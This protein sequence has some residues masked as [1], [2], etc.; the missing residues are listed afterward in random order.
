ML[1]LDYEANGPKIFMPTTAT[2]ANSF[3]A[4]LHLALQASSSSRNCPSLSDHDWLSI[5][6]LR[7]LQDHPSGRSFLL[8]LAASNSFKPVAS[9]LFFAGLASSRR[10]LLCAEVNTHLCSIL[11][12]QLPD[13][14]ADCPSL[15]GFDIYAGDGHYHAAACHD[16]PDSE[17]QT[18]RAVGH[19][20]TLNLRSH[21]LSYLTAADAASRKREHDMRALKRMDKETLRHG[22][23][24]GRKVIYIWDKA[25]ID[26]RAW[27]NWKQSAAIYFISRE[28]DNMKLT[29]NAVRPWDTSSSMN[30]GV[31]ADE[32]AGSSNGI[33]LR[34]VTYQDAMQGRTYTFITNEMTLEPGVIAHLYKMRWDIEKVFDELKNKLQE[35]KAWASSAVAKTMQAQFLCITHNLLMLC[36]HQVEQEHGIINEAEQT[37]R[38]K[39]LEEVK[40][41]LQNRGLKLPA[42]Q[43]SIQRFTQRSVKFIR[44]MRCYLFSTSCYQQA[45]SHLRNLY[46]TL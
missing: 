20:F 38:A 44:W 1:S 23:P 8:H 43:Q 46:A 21:A 22:A 32:L 24:K 40:S 4:P 41:S 17:S 31:Q 35:R 16:T 37:R 11:A 34:R 13:A 5:G 19:F 9:S 33:Q 14:L 3:F 12:H 2:L 18:R 25:G 36:E 6:T 30:A 28:K 45:L 15:A 42:L 10:G 27:Y 7:V 26:F 29:V 39:R